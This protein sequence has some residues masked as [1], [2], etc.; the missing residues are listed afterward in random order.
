[1]HLVNVAAFACTVLSVS[2]FQ[3]PD[4]VPLNRR[5][6]PGT[7]A[8]ECHANCGGVI[9]AGRTDGYCDA[10]N[11]K[12]ELSDCLNCALEFDIWKYYGGSVSKAATACGLD[13]T[14]LKVSST[15]AE[16]SSTSAETS[17]TSAEEPSTT[18]S[19]SATTTKTAEES[20]NSAVTT[21]AATSTTGPRVVST[22][23]SPPHVSGSPRPSS[24][25]PSAT[26]T[27]SSTA[28]I[29]SSSPVFNDGV[30]INSGSGIVSSAFVGCLIAAFL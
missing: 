24:L 26:P 7:P 8:Y 23:V 15:S 4:F 3:F 1:M 30:R 17:T 29:P 14:P 22:S 11:F 18:T 19:V 2:A 25:I 6:D 9:T 16:A 28:S 27:G 21:D 20:V 10:A 5:Q 13:A 12:T